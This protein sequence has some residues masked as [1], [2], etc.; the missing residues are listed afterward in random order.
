MKLH[1]GSHSEPP[2]YIFAFTFLSFRTFAFC[3]QFALEQNLHRLTCV[4]KKPKVTP[5]DN[6][7]DVFLPFP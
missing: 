2:L 7:N 6:Y 1:S 4:Y 3:Y 5:R